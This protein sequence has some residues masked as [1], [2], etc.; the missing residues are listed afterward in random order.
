MRD[1]RSRDGSVLVLEV[2]P[3]LTEPEYSFAR[4]FVSVYQVFAVDIV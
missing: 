4:P 1:V 3:D 2:G